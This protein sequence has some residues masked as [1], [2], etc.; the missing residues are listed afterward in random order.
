M[1]S[2]KALENEVY[3]TPECDVIELGV[4]GAILTNSPLNGASHDRFLEDDYSGSVKWE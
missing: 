2:K 1:E 3:V 4:E